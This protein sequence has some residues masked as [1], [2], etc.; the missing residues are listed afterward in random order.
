MR[1]I[2]VNNNSA[3]NQEIRLNDAAY[4]G[5]QRGRAEEMW[6]FPDIDFTKVAE[7]FGCAG[8]RVT[9]PGELPAALKQAIAMDRPVV[10]DVV[11]DMY[12]IA[13]KPWVPTGAVDFHSFQRSRS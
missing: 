4:G 3:L 11:S 6:R 2:V 13:K 5:K 7:A 9:N 8:I 12:A 10:V 1:V